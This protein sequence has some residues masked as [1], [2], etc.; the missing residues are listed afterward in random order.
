MSTPLDA[1][2]DGYGQYVLRLDQVHEHDLIYDQDTGTWA[3]AAREPAA[4]MARHGQRTVL[5]PVHRSGAGTEEVLEFK[6]GATVIVRRADGQA[7]PVNLKVAGPGRPVSYWTVQDPD[8]A[9]NI[10][11]GAASGPAEASPSIIVGEPFPADA[12]DGARRLQA[13]AAAQGW[14]T[15]W[16]PAGPGSGRMAAYHPN[17]FRLTIVQDWENGAVSWLTVGGQQHRPEDDVLAIISASPGFLPGTGRGEIT[18]DMLLHDHD[19]AQSVLRLDDKDLAAARAEF[20]RR[21]PLSPDPGKLRELRQT[22]ITEAEVRAAHAAPACERVPPYAAAARQ[23]AAAI[24]AWPPRTRPLRAARVPGPPPECSPARESST[25]PACNSTRSGS[26]KEFPPFQA[27]WRISKTAR[28]HTRTDTGEKWPAA[29]MFASRAAELRST[30]SDRCPLTDADGRLIRTG[31][32]VEM[33]S[34]GTA[35]TG[36][37]RTITLADTRSAIVL[38]DAIRLVTRADG[39]PPETGL[40]PVAGS[41][42]AEARDLADRLRGTAWDP[43]IPGDHRTGS[44]ILDEAAARFDAGD[45]AAGQRRSTRLARYPRERARSAD[46]CT[47]G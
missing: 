17:D 1:V 26:A 39:S 18:A 47:P 5:V 24:R 2:P 3:A 7:S 27:R 15:N 13:R 19:H 29:A 23:I 12:P 16:D 36:R 42:A 31:D 4:V 11:A 10:V 45:H 21:I 43:C 30:V 34:A 8:T 32:T 37:Y 28:R 44:A 6:P 41:P 25:P 40:R 20:D 14:D 33:L 38:S 46:S 9:A 35:H 22:V